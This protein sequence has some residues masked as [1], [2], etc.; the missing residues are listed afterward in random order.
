MGIHFKYAFVGVQFF[1]EILIKLK[2]IYNIHVCKYCLDFMRV[3]EM[4]K[5]GVA[6]ENRAKDD[7]SQSIGSIIVIFYQ[8]VSPTFK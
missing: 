8:F 3:L 5:L 2:Y 6:G 7:K 4:S 1:F